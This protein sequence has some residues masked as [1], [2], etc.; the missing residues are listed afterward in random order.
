MSNYDEF[1]EAMHKAHKLGIIEEVH[2]KAETYKNTD[3]DLY[4]R[5]LKAIKEV[6][7]EK[8]KS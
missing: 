1:E 3:T 5:Y 4:K 8:L 6:S 7:E 2:K